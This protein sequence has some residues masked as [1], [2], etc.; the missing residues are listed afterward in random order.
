M[1]EGEL[2][3]PTFP[4][5]ATLVLATGSEEPVTIYLADAG[6]ERAGPQTIAD[7]LNATKRF[8]PVRRGDG[9]YA[10]IRK[11]TVVLLRL[12]VDSPIEMGGEPESLPA[13]DL[14]HLKLD[15]GEEIDGVLTHIGPDDRSRLSDFFNDEDD[16]FQLDVAGGKVYVNKAHVASLEL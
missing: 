15:N 11:S 9:G 10:L 5:P 6:C 7:F 16:F 2:H 14:V 13:I 1:S 8:F 4:Q 12:D 3:V